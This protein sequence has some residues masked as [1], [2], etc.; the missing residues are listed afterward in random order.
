MVGFLILQIYS[1]R[2]RRHFMYI[3][4]QD[5]FICS[6]RTRTHVVAHVC[7]LLHTYVV[8]M[9]KVYTHQQ[10]YDVRRRVHF[11]HFQYASSCV[12]CHTRV[13]PI[14]QKHAFLSGMDRLCG[15]CCLFSA[16]DPIMPMDPGKMHAAAT[17][18]MN[19]NR[20]VVIMVQRAVENRWNNHIQFAS[21]SMI[22]RR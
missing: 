13:P 17:C 11:C 10:A 9:I 21:R 14:C 2:V 12:V 18:K 16:H 15:A 19:G 22:K 5:P 6:M 20:S 4:V 7:A 8:A 3:H 1:C